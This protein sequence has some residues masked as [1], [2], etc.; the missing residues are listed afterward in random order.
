MFHPR[1]FIL[2]KV[3][4]NTHDNTMRLHNFQKHLVVKTILGLQEICK[5]RT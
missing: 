3:L 5:G 2:I 1:Y 4:N